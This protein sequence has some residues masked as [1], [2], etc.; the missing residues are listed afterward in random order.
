VQV[1]EQPDGRLV[2]SPFHV[3][4]GKYGVLHSREKV[5]DIEVNGEPV[6]LRMKLGENGEAYFV[7]DSEEWDGSLH[8]EHLATR[9]VR[10]LFALFCDGSGPLKLRTR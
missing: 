7:D 10:R 1:V 5:V 2:A 4:F 8:P 6:D 9:F 3:R